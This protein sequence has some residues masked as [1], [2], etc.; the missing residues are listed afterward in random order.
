MTF[1]KEKWPMLLVSLLEI[2]I[3]IVLFIQPVNFTNIVIII[4]GILLAV[5]GVLCALKYLKAEPAV[6]AREQNL[7]KALILVAAGAFCAL[8]S[9]KVLNTFPSLPVLY[10][11]AILAMGF[12]KVQRTVDMLRAKH[13]QTIWAA[14]S[15]LLALAVGL[16]ILWNPFSK[17]AALWIFTGICLLVEAVVDILS[18][19]L[20]SKK[21]KPA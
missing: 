20:R 15:A 16:V 11:A 4:S 1:L 21:Q 6:A 18:L 8:G 10:G 17:P 12:F 7:A 13:E 19:F 5:R 14:A 9:Q 2:V 3:G